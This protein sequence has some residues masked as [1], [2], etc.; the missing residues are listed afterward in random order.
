[1]FPPFDFE[2][3]LVFVNIIN[4][5]FC[6]IWDATIY[7]RV[8]MSR[9][10]LACSAMSKRARSPRLDTESIFVTLSHDGGGEVCL[11]LK[12]GSINP[13]VEIKDTVTKQDINIG[14][15]EKDKE[16]HTTHKTPTTGRYAILVT[17]VQTNVPM[18]TEIMLR[19]YPD[20]EG[21][22]HTNDPYFLMSTAHN[23]QMICTGEV[24]GKQWGIHATQVNKKAHLGYKVEGE[25]AGTFCVDFVLANKVYVEASSVNN[26]RGGGPAAPNSRGGGPAAFNT[27]GGGAPAPS[28]AAQFHDAGDT[29]DKTEHFKTRLVGAKQRHS[30]RNRVGDQVELAT[31]PKKFCATKPAPIQ[32]DPEEPEDEVL[33]TEAA[34]EVPVPES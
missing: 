10:N 5:E 1:M 25:R 15:F 17:V 26:T 32:Q 16:G 27:R 13:N 24:T 28:W 8:W 14:F 23:T 6:S 19:G 11:R 20:V 21:Q 31:F 9:D 7:L 4:L 2:F 30:W 12:A 33:V 22:D 29:G 18:E 34:A 3:L